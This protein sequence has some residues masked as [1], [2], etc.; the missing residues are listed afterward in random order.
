MQATAHGDRFSERVVPQVKRRELRKRPSS[1]ET[2]ARGQ[3]WGRS[4][5][6]AASA[7]LAGKPASHPAAR[8]LG[9]PLLSTILMF[10][11]TRVSLPK[12]TRAIVFSARRYPVL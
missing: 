5:E 2:W 8:R 9:R 1:A 12:Q 4:K 3:S 10:A 7:R 6:Q 11:L